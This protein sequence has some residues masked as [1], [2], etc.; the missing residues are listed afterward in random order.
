[1][2]L[3]ARLTWPAVDGTDR[4]LLVTEACTIGRDQENH[5]VLEDPRSSKRHAEILPTPRG[6]QIR[7]LDSANGTLVNGRYIE[8]AVL[9]PGDTIVIGRT[10]IV[11]HPAADATEAV[12]APVRPAAAPI[13]APSP[14]PAAT[15][16]KDPA[17]ASLLAASRVLPEATEDGPS[18]ARPPPAPA[19]AA[20]QPSATAPAGPPGIP[21]PATGTPP[22]PAASAPPR[23]SAPNPNARAFLLTLKDLAVAVRAE[24]P[25]NAKALWSALQLLARDPFVRAQLAKSKASDST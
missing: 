25:E 22:R 3:R 10:P 4:E 17:L 23:A 18:A 11:F 24:R 19:P 16:R 7:D 8:E 2:T 14:P 13:D 6:F 21:P 15:A 9:K 1:M 20:P 12:P 5:I